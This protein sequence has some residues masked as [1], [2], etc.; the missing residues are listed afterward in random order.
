[1]ADEKTVVT[2]KTQSRKAAPKAPAAA[3]KK[4]AVKQAV[5]AAAGTVTKK[6]ATKKAVA[7]A[8][9]ATRAVSKKPPS[10]KAVVKKTTPATAAQP[11]AERRVSL[12]PVAKVT[13]EERYR[14]IADA[15]YYRAERRNFEP[16]HEHEDWLAAE[17]EVEEVLRR[18]R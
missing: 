5:T 10:K 17:A 12:A 8:P 11:R 14:M 7:S 2:K 4:T 6:T 16:G 9:A 18:R 1:M 3:A 15:A 13:P